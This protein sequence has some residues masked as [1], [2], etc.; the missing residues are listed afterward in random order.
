MLSLPR[1]LA[2]KAS[3]VPSGT[4]A[5]T[6]PRAPKTPFAAA[7]MC[8]WPPLP[9]EEHRLRRER[10]GR[11]D[12][13]V[14]AEDTLLGGEHVHRAALAAGIAVASSGELRHHA[15][16]IHA[17]GQHVAVVAVSGDDAV[18]R[19]QRHLHAD[20]D[21]L[22]ADVVM[23]EAAD[24]PHAVHLARLLLEAADQQHVLVGAEFL[25]FAQIGGRPC[26]VAG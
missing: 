14:A 8:I 7:H 23:A 25:L 20:D 1:Y 4:C 13:A 5:P 2:A 3:P 21:G 24:Q 9:R 19:L 18:A 16:G 6:M 10:H 12:I 26:I 22:L 17:A 15:L 11:P